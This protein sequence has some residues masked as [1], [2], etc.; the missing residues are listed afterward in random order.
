[1]RVSRVLTAASCLSV[2]TLGLT[3]CGGGSTHDGD[4]VGG[5]GG[6]GGL[7]GS[8]G[9]G[10]GAGSGASTGTGGIGAS[11]GTGGIG[12]STGAGGGTGTAGSGGSAGAGG[13]TAQVVTTGTLAGDQPVEVLFSESMD[14]SSLSLSGSLLDVAYS[15]SWSSTLHPEDTLVLTPDLRWYAGA[16]QTLI[17]SAQTTEGVTMGKPAELAVDVLAARIFITAKGGSGDLSTWEQA[18]QGSTGLSAADGICAAHAQ[19]AGLTGTFVAVLSDDDNDAYCRLHGYAGEVDSQCGQPELPSGAGPWFRT[20][21]LAAIGQLPEALSEGLVFNPVLLN[22]KGQG[23]GHTDV[24]YW[25]GSEPDGTG[26]EHTCEN[27]TS[28]AGD[29]KGRTGRARGATFYWIYQIT[30]GCDGSNRHLLCA[31]LE[32]GGLVRPITPDPQAHRVFATEARGPG[33]ISAE[34]GWADAG[35]ATGLAA[36]DA[37]CQA[38][39]EA[40]VPNPGT[41]VALLSDSSANAIDRVTAEGPFVRLDGYLVAT[42]KKELFSGALSTPHLTADGLY[43]GQGS[44]YGGAWLGSKWDGTV[45]DETC[46]D[47]TDPAFESRGSYDLLAILHADE[48]S[49]PCSYEKRLLCIEQ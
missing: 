34:G 24:Q 19:T 26:A 21:G 40:Y 42:E 31:Q 12:A 43:V 8:S 10:A 18:P 23:F 14:P 46:G 3:A 29:L 11:T 41:F 17:I 27:W 2:L 25:T 4:G 44:P 37:V 48:A 7:G 5:T 35:A 13:P 47:W 38:E 22:E 36:A 6:N 45:S 30:L 9:A 32:T 1:M 15:T 49:S 28:S 39:A 20:D 16:D 33:K